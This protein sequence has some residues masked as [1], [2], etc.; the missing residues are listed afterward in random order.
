MTNI[1]EQRNF[2]KEIYGRN[3]PDNKTIKWLTNQ[4]DKAQDLLVNSEEDRI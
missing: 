1:I 2:F 3:A 4:Y